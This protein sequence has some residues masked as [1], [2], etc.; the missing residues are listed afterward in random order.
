MPGD[1][2]LPIVKEDSHPPAELLDLSRKARSLGFFLDRLPDGDYVIIL[3]KQQ[4]AWQ[5]SV[6]EA[7]EIRALDLYR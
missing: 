3:H 5:A 2:T 4:R 6:M 1:D 7:Q